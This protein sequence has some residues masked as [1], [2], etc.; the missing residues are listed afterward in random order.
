MPRWKRA[1]A[2]RLLSGDPREYFFLNLPSEVKDG[3]KDIARTERKSGSWVV[4][5]AVYSY[6][7]LERPP[8][9]RTRLDHERHRTKRK[10]RRARTHHRVDS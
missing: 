10:R 5:E 2:P 8:M 6:F 1:Y 7:G 9:H 4:E 3:I